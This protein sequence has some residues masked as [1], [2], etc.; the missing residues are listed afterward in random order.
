MHL[1]A[2]LIKMALLFS[3]TCNR[4]L[5]SYQNGKHPRD[6]VEGVLPYT[7]KPCYLTYTVGTRTSV[8]IVGVSL[9]SGLI[10]WEN[11]WGETKKTV[12]NNK[13]SIRGGYL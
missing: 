8:Y 1:S 5:S 6:E 11:V 12:C 3:T 7:V 13:T 9:L 2:E 10:F 4:P